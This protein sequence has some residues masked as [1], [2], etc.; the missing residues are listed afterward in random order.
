MK[1][2]DELICEVLQMSSMTYLIA[3]D[4]LLYLTRSKITEH[5]CI[6]MK[7]INEC[8]IDISADGELV[9]VVEYLQKLASNGCRKYNRWRPSFHSVHFV[10]ARFQ[11]SF[12]ICPPRRDRAQAS[13]G[14]RDVHWEC[15]GR[16]MTSPAPFENLSANTFS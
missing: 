13:H 10:L 1:F 9:V 14:E 5:C 3:I 11:I 2:R 7:V 15:C 4:Q 16:S 6:T 8:M 12:K